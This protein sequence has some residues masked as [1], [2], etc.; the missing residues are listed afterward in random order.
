MKNPRYWMT[1][2]MAL[3]TLAARQLA[4][5]P[6]RGRS[7]RPT[8][9][10]PSCFSVETTVGR[11]VTA[12]RDRGLG[13]FASVE[14]DAGSGRQH[15]VLVLADDSGVTPVAQ[16]IWSDSEIDF[17]LEVSISELDDGTSLVTVLDARAMDD[18]EELP[19]RVVQHISS[20]PH[21]IESALTR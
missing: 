3:V 18:P 10:Q 12:A 5:G 21:L 6:M 15:R 17:P 8:W 4:D 11:I 16:D 20:L 9:S 2:S 1:G 7:S 14:A 13:L 19:E